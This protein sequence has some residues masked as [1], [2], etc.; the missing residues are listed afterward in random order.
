[1][2]YLCPSL[3]R[4]ISA[5]ILEVITQA[6]A[7]GK[8][9]VVLDYRFMSVISEIIPVAQLEG[10]PEERQKEGPSHQK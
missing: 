6:D 8:V 1:M 2:K 7:E 3:H 5:G 4:N 9:P 10:R